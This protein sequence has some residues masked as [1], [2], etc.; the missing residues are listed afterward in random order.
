MGQGDGAFV[1]KMRRGDRPN[2]LIFWY[3]QDFLHNN[4]LQFIAA[5]NWSKHCIFFISCLSAEGGDRQVYKLLCERNLSI[6]SLYDV[7]GRKQKIKNIQ[8]FD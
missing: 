6:Y 8:C 1:P 5:T 4:L 2:R 7:G 3:Y